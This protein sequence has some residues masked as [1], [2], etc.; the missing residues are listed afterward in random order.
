MI[1]LKL[2][3]VNGIY[4]PRYEV[5]F[6]YMIGDGDGYTTENFSCDPDKI[7]EVIKYVDILNRLKP[8]S[9]HWGICF[10][11]YPEEY[12]GEYIGLN[13]EEYKIL[14]HLINLGDE[15]KDE[16]EDSILSIE[17]TICDCLR[18]QIEFSFLVF[19]GVEIFYHGEDGRKFK[20]SWGEE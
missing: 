19:E 4:N 2:T 7:E 13:E 18:S 17:N 10:S 11:N 6:N 15:Y 9:R 14:I 12:P 8:L 5:I 3:P 16:D 1:N 20:V